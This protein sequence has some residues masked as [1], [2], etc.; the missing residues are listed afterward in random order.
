ME[1][2]EHLVAV[3]EL[4]LVE[5]H[6]EKQLEMRRPIGN[7]KAMMVEQEPTTMV[8]TVV[9]VDVTVLVIVQPSYHTRLAVTALL[10][11]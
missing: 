7:T 4:T 9:V 10:L 6:L 11:I 8:K 1:E 5:V 2:M 3:V